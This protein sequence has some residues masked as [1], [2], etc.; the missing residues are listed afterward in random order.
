LLVPNS[1]ALSQTTTIGKIENSGACS[2]TSI[3]A[4]N[5]TFNISK[6]CGRLSPDDAKQLARILTIA[7][8]NDL[9]LK[10]LAAQLALSNAPA[11][12][13]PVVGGV[14]TPDLS[15]G[16]TQRV[17]LHADTIIA[18]P[19][20]PHTS[21]D[22]TIK[23]TLFVDQDTVGEHKYTTDLLDAKTTWP[24]LVPNSRASYEFVTES[25]GHTVMRSVP[26]VNIGI[27]LPPKE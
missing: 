16:L 13:I 7:R 11:Y 21:K 23:W 10:D 14:A 15:H 9:S 20:L 1:L 5:S 19:R 26:I 17:L 3:N 6:G 24:G 8:K 2:F 18:A 12:T 25:P 4:N 27:D 22:E